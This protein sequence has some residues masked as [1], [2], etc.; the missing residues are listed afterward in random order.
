VGKIACHAIFQSCAH[1]FSARAN[2]Q[3]KL[4]CPNHHL[5]VPEVLT[6]R[7]IKGTNIGSNNSHPSLD[8]GDGVLMPKLAKKSEFDVTANVRWRKMEM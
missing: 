3:N 1:N 4:L 6:K 7:F 8:F 2:I 5:D